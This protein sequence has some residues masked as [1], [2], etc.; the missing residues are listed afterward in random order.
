[1]A[2]LLL[3]AV[4]KCIEF[5]MIEQFFH[6]RQLGSGGPV[7]RERL[8]RPEH[9]KLLKIELIPAV[10]IVY[11]ALGRVNSLARTKYDKH[12]GIRLIPK[13]LHACERRNIPQN[14]IPGILLL[15]LELCENC[16]WRYLLNGIVEERRASDAW[17]EELTEE[18]CVALA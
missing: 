7:P 5:R 4:M 3:G 10:D 14:F 17:S 15:Y 12:V 2:Y 16:E 1:L 18:V 8:F 11:A 6:N 9:V 13:V